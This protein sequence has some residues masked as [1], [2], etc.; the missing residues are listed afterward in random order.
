MSARPAEAVAFMSGAEQAAMM[1]R[2]EL[3][4]KALVELYLDRI[5]AYDA[6]LH[7]FITVCGAEALRAAEAADAERASGVVRVR[8]TGCRSRSRTSSR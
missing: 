1:A 3:T 5:A 4:S 2:G 7:A 6:G 8:C